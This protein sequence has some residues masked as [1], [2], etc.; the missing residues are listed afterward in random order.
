MHTDLMNIK[1]EL[2]ID[3]VLGILNALAE[4]PYK[5]VQR[6]I[7][8]ITAQVD[9]QESTAKNQTGNADSSRE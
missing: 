9:E 6:V 7:K 4:L 5:Q 3:D 2:P 1:L 8:S